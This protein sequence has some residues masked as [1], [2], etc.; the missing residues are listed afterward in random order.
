MPGVEK[1]IAS[2]NVIVRFFLCSMTH[3]LSCVT[4]TMIELKISY[5]AAAV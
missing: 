4:S 1:K 2:F 3:D 5:A